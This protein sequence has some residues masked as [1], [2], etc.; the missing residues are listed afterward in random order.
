[1][2]EKKVKEEN[3]K[4]DKD[5]LNLKELISF[6]KEMQVFTKDGIFKNLLS[7]PSEKEKQ[8]IHDLLFTAEKDLKSSLVLYKQKDYSNAVY[9]LQQS[10]EKLSKAC[11]MNFLS[12]N[13]DSVKNTSHN[14]PKIYLNL[15]QNQQ[16]KELIEKL[17]DIFPQIDIKPLDTIKERIESVGKKETKVKYAK[18]STTELTIL[19]DTCDKLMEID[20]KESFTD[21]LKKQYG[22]NLNTLLD[23][24]ISSV[25]TFFPEI[26]DHSEEIELKKHVEEN[27][28]IVFDPLNN[29]I[30]TILP[31][32][33]LGIIMY[34]HESFTRYPEEPIS[35]LDYNNE[36]GIVK[37]FKRVWDIEE[38]LLI[39]LKSY[40]KNEN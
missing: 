29:M 27:M 11:A 15:F 6:V 23:D 10:T 24:V 38:E 31:L 19:L 30:V 4:E 3:S 32:Y 22:T 26:D 8:V 18:M 34:S 2:V 12:M 25:L 21:S 37:V 20:I 39:K 35:N 13:S 7:V 28:G 14:T 1:M 5:E 16:I 9:L 36:F 17:A 33:I 40:I